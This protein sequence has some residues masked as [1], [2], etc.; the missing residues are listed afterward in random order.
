MQP[1]KYI[2]NIAKEYWSCNVESHRHSS[3]MVA[4]KCLDRTDSVKAMSDYKQTQERNFLDKIMLKHP[5]LIDDYE[6]GINRL[7]NFC[8]I[9]LG[10]DYLIVLT[11]IYTK[12]NEREWLML[13]LY[14]GIQHREIK[15]YAEIARIFQISQRS[16]KDIFARNRWK[17]QKYLSEIKLN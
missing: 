9:R 1:E 8:D 4:L 17:L 11:K 16:C 5:L 3:K 2:I 13:R 12:L 15:N 14:F 10:K 7:L 6:N